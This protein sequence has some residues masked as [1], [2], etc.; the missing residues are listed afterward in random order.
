MSSLLQTSVQVFFRR[1]CTF[2]YCTLLLYVIGGLIYIT[3]SKINLIRSSLTCCNFI[4]YCNVNSVC[5]N[6]EQHKYFIPAIANRIFQSKDNYSISNATSY[7]LVS[8]DK[9]N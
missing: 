9:N 2:K 6:P 1:L 4:K 3:D 7:N 5:S 8:T